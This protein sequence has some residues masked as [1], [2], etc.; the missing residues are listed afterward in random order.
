MRQLGHP[1]YV[2]GVLLSPPVTISH[3]P[4]PTSGADPSMGALGEYFSA[5]GEYVSYLPTKAL[6]A[7]QVVPMAPVVPGAQPAPSSG[8]SAGKI[9][10]GVLGVAST[11]ALAYHGYRR[12]QSIGWSLVWAI[13]G[14]GFPI[15]GWP[16]AI[17]QGFGKSKSY[18]PNRRRASKRK[19]D[20]DAQLV[21]LAGG[22]AGEN[23]WDLVSEFNAA[24]AAKLG[25]TRFSKDE[26]FTRYERA[27]NAG[28]KR[29]GKSRRG[30]GARR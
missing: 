29:L 9:I 8:P 1:L 23:G 26:A 16:I 20:R 28:K 27:Y 24:W 7:D 11:A 13:F 5:M 3:V 15:I 2:N 4:G 12:N 6:G 30:K 22:A 18:S 14:G 10:L 19:I 17:A 21:R 25:D